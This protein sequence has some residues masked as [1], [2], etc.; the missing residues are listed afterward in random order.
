M[1]KTILFLAILASS[2]TSFAAVS[3]EE[4]LRKVGK[5]IDQTTEQAKAQVKETIN[6]LKEDNEDFTT[7]L[8][9]AAREVGQGFTRAWSRLKGQAQ[10]D[11]K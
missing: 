4:E 8:K 2:T 7:R 9:G 1:K 11:S 6:D 3:M 5:K 10:H